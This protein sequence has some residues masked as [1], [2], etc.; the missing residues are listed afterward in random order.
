MAAPAIHWNSKVTP[1]FERILLHDAFLHSINVDWSGATCTF[2]LS[3]LLDGMDKP[4]IARNLR[5]K[6]VEELHIPHGVP[7]GE[8]SYVNESKQLSAN[9]FSIQMQSGDDIRI[10]ADS[11]EIEHAGAAT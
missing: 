6:G 2:I 5:F 3:A 10:V 7:W 11:F 4:G 9:T 8:S 1:D